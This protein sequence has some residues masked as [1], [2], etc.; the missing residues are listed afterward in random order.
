V[1]PLSKEEIAM[2][3]T[4]FKIKEITKE[5]EAALPDKLPVTEKIP[6]K[7]K[8]EK[9][10]SE[11][12]K[13]H[14]DTKD[15]KDAKEQ[16]DKQEKEKHEKEK[17]EKDGKSESKDH[18]DKVKLEKEVRDHKGVIKEH[19]P[20]ET[21]LEKLPETKTAESETGAPAATAP[22]AMADALKIVDK[23]IE[24]IQKEKDKFEKSEK[25]EKFEIKEFDKV[26]HDVK[27]FEVPPIGPVGPGPVEE[28]LSA[29]EAAVSQLVHFIP[30]NLR[31]DLSK[32]ALRQE[33]DA[34]KKETGG[35]TTGGE[36]SEPSKKESEKKK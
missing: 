29:L 35:A 6:T 17:Q 11:A 3:G 16:K 26:I 31:P 9:E 33:A 24:K 28:R 22:E 8:H 34:E 18:A 14:K 23:V 1:A 7:D 21:S 15:Q 10:K 36:P 5:K 32:G 30:E 25:V 13:P 4:P 27:Y 2:A 12:D 19:L 20:K